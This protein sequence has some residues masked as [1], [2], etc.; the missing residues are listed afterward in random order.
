MPSPF[1]FEPLLLASLLF[2]SATGLGASDRPD[3]SILE[4]AFDVVLIPEVEIELS[5][6][7]DDVDWK[8]L[9]VLID[10]WPIHDCE[11]EWY[12]ASCV[13]Q[14]LSP[15]PHKIEAQVGNHAGNLATAQR[16]FT[17]ARDTQPPTVVATRPRYSRY[18]NDPP[19]V[20]EFGYADIDTG[21]DVSAVYVFLD[22]IEITSACQ[23]ASESVYCRLPP[24]EDL[25]HLVTAL[26]S[27]MVGNV[28]TASVSFVTVK[29]DPPLEGRPR[30]IVDPRDPDEN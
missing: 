19:E 3:V 26:V 16:E 11:L 2:C 12:G 5:Y 9:V 23:I 27:D 30:C 18:L 25:D 20:A 7:E 15:G 6:G 4:P 29:N 8:N 14:P 13:T 28:E 21:I 17:L 1:Q 10:G 24:M 22:G